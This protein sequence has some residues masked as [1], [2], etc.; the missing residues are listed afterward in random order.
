VKPHTNF[1]GKTES[2]LVKMMAIGLGNQVGAEHYHRLTMERG[3]YNVISTAGTELIKRCRV[4][5]GVG[6]VE[7]Q[8]HETCDLKMAVAEDIVAV[9]TA[10]LKSARQYLPTLPLDKIDLLVVDELGKDISGEGIDP[11]VVGR[12]VCTC[13]AR[14]SS[15]KITRIFVRDLTKAS[16]GAALGIGQADF[17]VKRLVDKIDFAVTAVNCLTSC[18]PESGMVP[19]TFATD[20]EAV[21]AALK[22]IRPY[23]MRDLRLVHIKNTL[24]L[25][26]LL[27]S[28][29]CLADLAGRADVTVDPSSL[30]LNFDRSGNLISLWER[31]TS[32]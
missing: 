21:A 25:A 9:E 24:D 6:L 22:T 32:H 12:D 30:R 27:V 26:C 7:N 11:N 19:L 2:G 23:T 31:E 3:Y 28:E 14:R 8:H 17:T 4:L 1:F 20:K 29:G 18:C 16:E 5:F 10:L 15:P 13:G